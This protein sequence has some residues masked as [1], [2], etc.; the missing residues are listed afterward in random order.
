MNLYQETPQ[1]FATKQFNT[2]PSKE[3]NSAFNQIYS[4]FQSK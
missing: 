2:T 3:N 1:I 4:I